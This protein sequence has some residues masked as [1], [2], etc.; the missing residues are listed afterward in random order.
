MYKTYYNQNKR[1]VAGLYVKP[2]LKFLDGGFSLGISRAPTY[3][4]DSGI[5]A[6]DYNMYNNLVIL[7][8]TPF[9][10]TPYTKRSSRETSR[11]EKCQSLLNYSATSTN[12]SCNRG[13]TNSKP[14]VIPTANPYLIR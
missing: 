12:T 13:W 14:A 11:E 1:R 7:A 3:H 4:Y 10:S 9:T 2:V 5:Y 6:A 8:I